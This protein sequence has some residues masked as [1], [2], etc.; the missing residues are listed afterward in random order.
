MSI[1]RLLLQHPRIVI[2]L[3]VVAAVGLRLTVRLVRGE[4][5]FWEGGY[6]FYHLYVTNLLDGD[7]LCLDEGHWPGS[8][9][10]LGP[11][12]AFHPP[13][14]PYYLALAM[15]LG[16]ENEF[17][18]IAVMQSLVGAGTVFCVFLVGREMF[19]ARA[20]M[21]AS[22]FAAVYPYYVWHDTALQE[23]SVLTF[24]TVL[25]VVLFYRAVHKSG[26]VS[27]AMVGLSLGLAVLTKASLASF[28]FLL[29]ASMALFVPGALRTRL[30]QT[31]VLLL[32]FVVTLSP[33]LVR[34]F[35]L[36]GS[37][38]LTSAAGKQLWLINNRYSF[39]HYPARNIDL[40]F[41]EAQ[42]NLVVST[43]WSQLEA[44]AGDE[45]SQQRWFLKQGLDF[46]LQNPFLTAQRAV[47]KVVA[48]FSWEFSP[49]KEG[50]FQAAYFL[51]YFPIFTLGIIG[52]LL[53]R[54]LWREQLP[55]YLLFVG[56]VW[57]TV[58][59]HAHTSHRTYLDVYLMIFAAYAIMIGRAK[60]KAALIRDV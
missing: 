11:R 47:V 27:T 16:A 15:F 52:A 45:L 29:V 53:S 26:V 34:N 30:H 50:F 54:R 25:S 35:N 41:S 42:A 24:M 20:G 44:L 38:V 40:D 36:L 56:F 8:L 49:A 39:R 23:T 32:A 18:S 3:I 22:L 57:V 1:R 17:L 4:A 2:A 55:V 28:A 9:P 60:W 48:A 7:G 5:S 6:D 59:F 58:V 13:V 37:P 31:S 14:Y 12:C 19:D 21:L 46:I 33:W 43:E 10:G 51:S